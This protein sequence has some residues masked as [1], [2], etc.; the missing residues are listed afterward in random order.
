MSYHRIYVVSFFLILFSCTAEPETPVSAGDNEIQQSFRKAPANPIIAAIEEAHQA[1][2]FHQKEA[3]S[4][5]IE[6][7][8]RG[9]KRMDWENKL[10]RRPSQILLSYKIPTLAFLNQPLW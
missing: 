1:D 3:I 6:L 9:Q 7:F 5:D 2:S 10:V 4:F 8:F